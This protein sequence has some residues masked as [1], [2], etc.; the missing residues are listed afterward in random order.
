MPTIHGVA[1]NDGPATH[2]RPLR[3]VGVPAAAVQNAIVD[4]TVDVGHSDCVGLARLTA[5]AAMALESLKD[6][7]LDEIA[8]LM[9]V[10]RQALPEL[11]RLAEVAHAPELREALL[12]HADVSRLHVE[13]LELIRA[14]HAAAAPC[15]PSPAAAALLAQVE[16]RIADAGTPDVRDAAII[17]MA[18]RL[19]HYEIAAY[20]CARAYARRLDRHDDADLLETSLAEEGIADHRLTEIADAHVNDDARTE[21]DLHA[22]LRG[23]RLRY[24]AVERLDVSRLADPPLRIRNE[25]REDFGRFDG[26]LVDPD[27]GRPAYVVLDARGFLSGRRRLVPVSQLRFD[28]RERVLRLDVDKDILDR[29][30]SFEPREFQVL[31]EWP[32]GRQARLADLMEQAAAGGAGRAHARGGAAPE[33][34]MTGVWLVVPSGRAGRVDEGV[35]SFANEF[36][37]RA[38]GRSSLDRD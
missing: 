20:G 12:R 21:A 29:Y 9:Q 2:G 23:S 4:S 25:G 22:L 27:A 35:N 16:S 11:Q 3:V 38:A 8:D 28:D 30:P 26:I 18:Q 32:R 36:N 7:Y 17:G 34:L 1:R 10:E 14:R 13:R 31:E 15:G 33:W 24:V 6:L 5:E 19:E 37:P